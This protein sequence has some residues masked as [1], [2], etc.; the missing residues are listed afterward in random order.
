MFIEVTDQES[1]ES[2][3]RFLYNQTSLLHSLELLH[4]SEW[5]FKPF[6]HCVYFSDPEAMYIFL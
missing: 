3:R 1:Q 6:T 5:R 2:C 4:L